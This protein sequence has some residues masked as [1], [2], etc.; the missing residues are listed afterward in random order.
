MRDRFE[1]SIEMSS[2][3]HFTDK[4]YKT[5]ISGKDTQSTIA[6]R[7]HGKV[8]KCEGFVCRLNQINC[9]GCISPGFVKTWCFSTDLFLVPPKGNSS[10]EWRAVVSVGAQIRSKKHL[11]KGH[12]PRHMCHVTWWERFILIPKLA[13]Q[14]FV[15]LQIPARERN[16]RGMSR[17][18]PLGRAT[19]EVNRKYSEVLLLSSYTYTFLCAK[20]YVS[21]SA[22]LKTPAA[23]G[24]IITGEVSCH[25]ETIVLPRWHRW[26]TSDEKCLWAPFP[27]YGGESVPNYIE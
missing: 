17:L 16:E 13:T 22:V 8:R 2:F 10:Q 18:K 23:R 26:R 11:D 3:V 20:R 1:F 4:A 27:D 9:F 15:V 14:R 19:M 6:F 12:Q 25:F 5:L 7:R 21:K 24:L